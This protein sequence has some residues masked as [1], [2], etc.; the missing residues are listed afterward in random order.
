MMVMGHPLM[1]S[2]VYI[3]VLLKNIISPQE[4]GRRK[5]GGN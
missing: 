2:S 3:I 1:E 4:T 5:R